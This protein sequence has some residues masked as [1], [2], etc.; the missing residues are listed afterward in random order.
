MMQKIGILG[1][2]GSIGTQ[3]LDIISDS[4]DYQ[5]EYLSCLSNFD[6]LVEQCFKHHPAKVCIVDKNK[7]KLLINSLKDENIEVLSGFEGLWELSKEPV[8]LML[9]SIVGSDGMK[10]SI[11]ALENDI[12]LALAN[13]ESMVMAGWLIKEIQKN[14]KNSIIPVDSEHSAIFQC[15]KGEKLE[16]VKRIILTGSGGPFR[17]KNINDFGSITLNEALNHPNWEM[18][19][20]I[21]IDSA[22]MMNKGLEYIEAYWLF[23][24]PCDKIDIVVHPQSIIHSMVEFIDGSIKAQMGEPDMKVPIQYAFTYPLRIKNSINN[25]DFMVNNNLTFEEPDLNKFPCIKLAK[26]ALLS[27]GSYQVVLN[28]ANDFLVGNFLNKRIHFTDIPKMIEDC[29]SRHSPIES[30][31]LDEIDSLSIWTKEYLNKEVLNA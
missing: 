12:K 11:I 28:V 17:Q 7:E 14:K 31:T 27:G 13:K 20:K 21:T 8:D 23:D 22:T 15:L 18:G 16:D 6:K 24:L 4:E 10:P 26:D 30:P 29:I 1:S 19:S 9:N 5:V 2:T 3:A 25:F